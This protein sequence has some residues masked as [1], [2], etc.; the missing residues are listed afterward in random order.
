MKVDID[1]HSNINYM[2]CLPSSISFLGQQANLIGPSLK[3]IETM[4]APQNGMFCFE[5]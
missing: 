5:V 2:S 3:K 4:E 1:I